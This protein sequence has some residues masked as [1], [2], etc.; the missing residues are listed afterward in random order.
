[1]AGGVLKFQA[2]VT[3]G[4]EFAGGFGNGLSGVAVVTEVGIGG[5]MDGRFGG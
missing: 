3:E 5:R 4:R 2:P 1:M